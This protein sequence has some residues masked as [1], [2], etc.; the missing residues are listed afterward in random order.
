[1]HNRQ[2]CTLYA[3]KSYDYR[4]PHYASH[5]GVRVPQIVIRK[6]LSR[7]SGDWQYH[8]NRWFQR[9]RPE[10]AVMIAFV[11]VSLAGLVVASMAL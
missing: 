10:A 6:R 4:Y 3:Q 5:R 11:V 7:R 9:N 1:M 2:G 8:V